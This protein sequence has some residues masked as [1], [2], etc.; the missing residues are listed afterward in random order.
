VKI[1]TELSQA[2]LN[3]SAGKALQTKFDQI[4]SDARL[5]CDSEK[6]RCMQIVGSLQYVATVTRPDISFAASA[7]ARFLTCPTAHLMNCAEKV[8]RYLAKTKKHRLT[9]TK[10]NLIQLKGYSDADWANCEMTRKST[11]GFVI[12]INNAPVY[13]RSK[14]QPIVTMSSTE[15]ELVALT[16]LAL[17]VK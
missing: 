7:L 2:D 5:L 3:S 10:A 16:E 4:D 6:Q 11:S 12:Y 17:Q 13:W 9:Y 1:E 8:S 15:A 14:R